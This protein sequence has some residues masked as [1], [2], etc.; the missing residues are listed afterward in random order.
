[1]SQTNGQSNGANGHAAPFRAIVVGAGLAGLA[2]AIALRGEGRE[3]VVLESSR[4][5]SEIGA[6]IQ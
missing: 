6:A 4:M 1:M 2:A 3:V 5:K